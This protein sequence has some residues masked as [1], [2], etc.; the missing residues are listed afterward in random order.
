MG[1]SVPIGEQN[2]YRRQ[3][4]GQ[5]VAEARQQDA[6]ALW[7]DSRPDG[8]VLDA[9]DSAI[10]NYDVCLAARGQLA[11]QLAS[12][13]QAVQESE[14]EGRS[15]GELLKLQQTYQRTEMQMRDACNQLN[16]AIANAFMFSEVARERQLI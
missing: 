14:R 8:E 4:I 1:D 6:L 9:L 16:S 2:E 13:S 3:R 12:A 15:K 11:R 10:A 7:L 5:L